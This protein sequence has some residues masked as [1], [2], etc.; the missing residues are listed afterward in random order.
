M[1]SNVRK[2]G[3]DKVFLFFSDLLK[4]D[5][6]IVFMLYKSAHN[7]R[8]AADDKIVLKLLPKMFVSKTGNLNL[9][10]GKFLQKF[11]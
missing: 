5:E 4:G 10:F 6:Y 1:F 2:I 9:F 8:Q 11:Q 3:G 7:F